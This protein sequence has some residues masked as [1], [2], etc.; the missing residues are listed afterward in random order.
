ML[1]FVRFERSRK[2]SLTLVGIRCV[3]AV[4]EF[5]PIMSEHFLSFSKIHMASILLRFIDLVRSALKFSLMDDATEIVLVG[6]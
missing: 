6:V 5:S 1:S 2:I 3:Q 4:L